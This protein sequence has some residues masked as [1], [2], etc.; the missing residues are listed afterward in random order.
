M[1]LESN[2]AQN[3]NNFKCQFDIL[4]QAREAANMADAIKI[5]ILLNC[6]GEEVT[7]RFDQLK[8]AEPGED[9][10]PP[11]GENPNKYNEVVKKLEEHFKGKKRL[12]VS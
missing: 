2:V 8:W 9:G 10:L 7:E 3:W 12:F 5:A 1:S 11:V 4:L 6:M